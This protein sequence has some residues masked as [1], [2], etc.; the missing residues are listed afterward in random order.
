MLIVLIVALHARF[1][2]ANAADI[3]DLIMFDDLSEMFAGL[4]QRVNSNNTLQR[5]GRFCSAEFL[6]QIGDRTFYL[7]IERGRL[8]DVIEG[9]RHMRRWCFAIRAPMQS[10]HC[11]WQPVPAA[12][13]HDIFAMT[14]F[15]HAQIEG[16]I[17]TL[18][19]HL[20]YFKDLLAL[21][22]TA[23]PGLHTES[24]QHG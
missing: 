6:L 9:P 17:G 19:K 5:E 21:P 13:Y 15:G 20:R 1:R 3:W 18:L 8:L 12:G 7:T 22:R 2:P 10:W 24:E 11:F 16:D 4:P 23:L 14:T